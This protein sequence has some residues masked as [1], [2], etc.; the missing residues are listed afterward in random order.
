MKGSNDE[1]LFISAMREYDLYLE[2]QT[3]LQQEMKKG[4]EGFASA[5]YSTPT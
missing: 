2:S 5:R 3:R 1:E 4:F